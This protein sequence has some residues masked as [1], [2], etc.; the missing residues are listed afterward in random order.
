M[1]NHKEVEEYVGNEKSLAYST[2][3][4]TQYKLYLFDEIE[5]V[6]DYGDILNVLYKAGSDDTV[7]LSL[8]SPG[9]CVDTGMIICDAIRNCK[10]PVLISITAPCYSMASIIALHATHL[11][12]APGAFL[13]FH[14]I[15][16]VE[17]GKQGEIAASHLATQKM[18]GVIYKTM[19]SP[20]LTDS[21]ITRIRKGEDIYIHGKDIIKRFKRHIKE[22]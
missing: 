10:A 15:S 17:I 4:S 14:D 8:N 19:C 6:K 2:V 21:E 5:S 1:S 12:V 7:F 3:T 18:A 22:K 13:M 11:M 20:F 9:G 16:S